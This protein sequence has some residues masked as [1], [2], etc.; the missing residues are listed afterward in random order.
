MPCHKAEQLPK[1]VMPRIH[2]PRVH[3]RVGDAIT[4]HTPCYIAMAFPRL[5]PHGTGDYHD[6]ASGLDKCGFGDWGR[7]AMLWHDQ[8]FMRHS[9]FRY[10]F[11]KTALRTKSPGARKNFTNQHPEHL[12]LTMDNVIDPRL[13]R[14]IVQQ[15]STATAHIPGSVGKKTDATRVRSHG[16]PN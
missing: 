14:Q 11:L 2:A 8:R 6:R 16:G 13:R 7:Y 15:M 12:D 9:R 3:D 1:S 4:E 5:S 10:W